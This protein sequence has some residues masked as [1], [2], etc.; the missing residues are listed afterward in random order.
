L[1]ISIKTPFD[2]DPEEVIEI[3]T[4]VAG[5]HPN[6]HAE[7]SPM[8]VFN[9]Y[10]SYAF[11]FTLYCW[12]RFNVSF[13]TKSD[14]AIEVFKSLAAAGIEAPLPSQKIKIDPDSKNNSQ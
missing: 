6:T 11:D 2:A 8:A 13:T 1:E 12:V 4:K 9:G 7:P 10:E 3:L 5:E 14:I